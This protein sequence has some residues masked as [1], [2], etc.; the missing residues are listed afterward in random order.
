MKISE[1]LNE[2]SWYIPEALTAYFGVYIPEFIILC[3]L[4]SLLSGLCVFCCITI[5]CIVAK[6]AKLLAAIGIYYGASAVYSMF[7]RLILR[8]AAEPLAYRFSYMTEKEIYGACAIIGLGII[9]LSLI[10]CIL[11]YALECW[12]LNDKLNLE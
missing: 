9:F 5:A 2:V 11:L 8:I 3:L 4:N 7:I 10:F 6:K 12:L 1:V